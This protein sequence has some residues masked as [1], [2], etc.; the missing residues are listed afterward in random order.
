MSR[1]SLG[2]RYALFLVPFAG[3]AFFAFVFGVLLVQNRRAP[4]DDL[5]VW[6]FLAAQFVVLGASR[7]H[8]AAALVAS[9]AL[10]L[11]ACAV[12]RAPNEGI[13]VT[14]FLAG[15]LYRANRAR[16][17]GGLHVVTSW[18]GVTYR[19]GATRSMV[20]IV[21]LFGLAPWLL[22]WPSSPLYPTEMRS[23]DDAVNTM[24][25]VLLV[26][27]LQT[28]W[29]NRGEQREAAVKRASEAE[30]ARDAAAE[31]ERA[32]IARELHDVVAHQ[33]AVVVSQAQGAE[34]IVATDPVRAR[35]ALATIASTTREALVEMR[36]LVGVT[37]SGGG[38]VPPEAGG[39]QPGLS[40][41]D[42][43]R[44]AANAEA[45]GLSD[46]RVEY[47]GSRD[48]GTPVPAGIA[49][50][51]YRVIQEALTNAAKHA[52]GALVQVA[53][54]DD[55]ASLR[56]AVTNGPAREDSRDVPGSGVGLVG[57]RER[58]TIFGGTLET[59]A[60]DDGGWSVVARFPYTGGSFDE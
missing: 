12:G 47:E 57:M 26:F 9:A 18:G 52:P 6:V 13:G 51:A 54:A 24:A 14:V 36:R 40:H 1:R 39:P 25:I 45:A 20:T 59:G 56:V 33:M 2:E 17:S 28:N 60:T 16:S 48:D 15:E 35:R 49:L 37:P 50:A 7:R 32:R 44:L 53:V 29:T 8:R 27:L 41:E 21:A 3:E 38:D 46:V 10:V 23:F 58:V 42:L 4:H 30:S 31:N 43:G 55:E 34:A 22:H 5:W 19:A 11:L